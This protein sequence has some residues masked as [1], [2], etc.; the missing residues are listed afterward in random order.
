[1]ALTPYSSTV[2]YDGPTTNDGCITI[3]QYSS[4]NDV[5][6]TI[7]SSIDLCSLNYN[8]ITPVTKK[9]PDVIQAILNN[10]CSCTVKVSPTDTC[11]D[12]LINKI[13]SLDGSISIKK[14]TN[15]HIY[16]AILLANG[17]DGQ[18]IP[19][20]TIPGANATWIFTS[21]QLTY[22][23]TFQIYID[24]TLHN[25]G[26]ITSTPGL[27]AALNDL[28]LGT[29]TI[30]GTTI[31]VSNINCETIDLSVT[32][33]N[34]TYPKSVLYSNFTPV[35]LSNVTGNLHGY[36]LPVNT[37]VNNGDTINITFSLT[38][39]TG[40]NPS[41]NPT[42]KLY[43]GNT[44]NFTTIF[45]PNGTSIVYASY[46]LIRV[47]TTQV[48]LTGTYYTGITNEGQGP[49]GIL[50]SQT[51]I[52]IPLYNGSPYNIG[53]L[54]VT[55]IPIQLELVTTDGATVQSDFLTIE[56]LSA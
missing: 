35:S 55:P 51:F 56:K 24:N 53:T 44:A 3:C 13:T 46:K 30:V 10:L 20:Y 19:S 25:L 28:N 16:G 7:L 47:S 4:L 48:Q 2:I 23:E 12:Y 33:V 21:S 29:F 54:S 37:L 50:V 14:N 5:L 39:N 36:T 40:D 6:G 22:T 42:L 27:L 11:C 49:S 31:S 52:T 1:M 26:P 18:V 8:C 15:I 9:L 32:P 41:F 45:I 34:I 38:K 17:D 43:I